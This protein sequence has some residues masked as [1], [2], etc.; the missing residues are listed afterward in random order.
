MKIGSVD[1]RDRVLIVAEVGNNHEGDF[2]RARTMI[3]E[4]ARAGADVVKFQTIVPERLVSA[5]QSDRL[6]QLQRFQ[7]ARAEFEALAAEARAAGIMF[8]ST[9][10]DVESVAWLD[11][12]VPAFKVASGDNDFYPLLDRVAATG[13]PVM[14]SLGFGG[15]A[16][17]AQLVDYFRGA[18]KR[19]GMSEPGL[20][21]LH[22]VAAYPTPDEHANLG[23]IRDLLTLGVTVGYS[24][25]TLGIKAGE[26][27]VAAG[28]RIVEKHFTLDKTR[29]S[30]RDHQLSA[31]PADLRALVSAI[32]RAE[33]MLAT[34]V[35]GPADA[36]NMAAR[37]SIAASR[38]LPAGTVIGLADLTWVRPGTGL[39]P[40]TESQVIGRRLC[41]SVAAGH[42]I[43][44]SDLE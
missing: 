39:R 23:A 22:C 7:L 41:A 25:H 30:F 37:R 18:W 16:R 34:P 33:L 3:Q 29:T 20:A 12:L 32:R 15:A 4:A 6:A 8:L 9:P 40:G 38:N 1:T 11:P 2:A 27:A 35:A 43:K 21:L 26:L 17:A 19:R 36:G 5:D 10:F 24:D 14:V 44:P 31:D 13:K 42:L 28:A